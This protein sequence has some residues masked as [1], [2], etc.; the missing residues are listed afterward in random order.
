MSADHHRYMAHAL[1]LGR[2]RMGQTWP[3]PA[4]G[5]VIVKDGRI[6]GRGVTAPGGRPHAEPQALAQAGASARGTTAY[7]SLE[8]CAHHGET[9]P[10]AAAL[11]DAG[12]AHVVAPLADSDPRVSGQGFA[13]LRDAGIKVTTGVLAD[14]AARDHA[15]F[16]LRT[17]QGRPFVTLKL[18]S[19][20]DGRIATATGESQWITGPQARRMVHAMRACHDA[21]MVGGGTARADDPSLTVRDMGA[22]RQPVRIVVSRRLDLPMM[23]RLARSAREIPLWLAHGPDIDPTLHEAWEGIGAR[24]IPCAVSAGQLDLTSVLQELGRAGLTRVFCEGGGG[25]AASLLVSDLVDELVGFT[26]GLGIGAE[27]LPAI[28]GLGLAHLSDAPRFALRDTRPIGDDVLH[29]W[30]RS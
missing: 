19:S 1:A 23:S 8:P 30:Q 20:F 14:E 9:P 28:G 16:F 24:L 11:I 22:E 6:V 18:A 25:L 12:V 29:I 27:G 5:C 2:R 7:V 3:N 10:C 15:G 21:V 4:V 13:M 26:A 17:E